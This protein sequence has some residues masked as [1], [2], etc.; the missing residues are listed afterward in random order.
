MLHNDEP[1]R[2]IRLETANHQKPFVVETD[3]V[4]RGVLIRLEPGRGKQ[5]GSPS[6][7]ESRRRRQPYC[8][9][10]SDCVTIESSFP[11][12]DHCGSMPP[13]DD[14]AHFAAVVFGNGTT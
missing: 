12:C 7:R 1:V 8:S 4:L 11:L 14:I 10:V 13:P 9:E 2:R 3:G 5:S 6:H